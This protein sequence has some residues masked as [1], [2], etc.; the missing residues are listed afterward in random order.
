MDVTIILALLLVLTIVAT[1]VLAK[2]LFA[3]RLALQK[4]SGLESVDQ[5]KAEVTQEAQSK[6]AEVERLSERKRAI[7]SQ[8][9]ALQADLRSVEDSLEIQS[10][11]VYQNH[12]GFPD[13]SRYQTELGKIR[14]RIKKTIKE[15]TAATCATE[16]TVEGS[17]AKGRKMVKQGI[18]LMLRA[19]NGEC[20]G[21]ISK[22]KYNNVTSLESRIS[23]AF[24]AINKLGESN[25][26]AIQRSYLKLRLA[27]LHL[28]HEHREMIQ[29]EREEQRRIKEE[30]REEEKAQKELEKAKVEAEKEEARQQKALAKARRELAEATGAQHDKLEALVG[31]L[32]NELRDVLERKAKAI[33]RAQL[34]RSGHVYVLSN[35][36]SF[37]EGVYK[38]GMTRRL[39]PLDRVKELGDASVPFRF[40][41][42]AMI[43][44]EDAPSLEN[45]LH[46]EFSGHRVNMVNLR[47]EYFRVSLDDIRHAV[48]KHHG[49]V[50]FVTSPEA[51][52]YRKTVSIREAE[53]NRVTA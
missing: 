14:D 19:F 42:H 50:T 40:D 44:A 46:K 29:Q 3:S 7:A 6:L 23:K 43:Y 9:Q 47:R 10:F 26:I 12:Y 16:W 48:A 15:G 21:A 18:K 35:I 11:G 45:A 2:K 8:V 32:E 4:Y 22:V 52:E 33:A 17:K 41:V 51:E 36:G 37:G 13:S 38:I 34:T 27:E 25:Q 53:E 20:E 24:E 30:M 31:R 5:Y 39:E 1:A 28:V 49:I